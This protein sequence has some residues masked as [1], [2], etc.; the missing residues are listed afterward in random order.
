VA[1]SRGSAG[2]IHVLAIFYGNINW[3]FVF[4]HFSA[5]EEGRS[6]VIHIRLCDGYYLKRREGFG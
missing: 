4:I 3:Y 6:F 5:N 2:P 1:R